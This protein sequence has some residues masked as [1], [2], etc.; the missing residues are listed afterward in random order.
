MQT[1]TYKLNV[2][3]GGIPLTI[4]ISQY[5]VGLRQYTFEPYTTVGSFSYVAGATVTLEATKPDGYAVIHDCDYNQDGSITYTVQEQLA[6]K[7]GRVW[8]KIVIRDG[9]DVLGTGA[10]VWVVD[11]AGMKDGTIVSTSDI[12]GIRGMIDTAV[13]EAL[14]DVD[15]MRGAIVQRANVVEVDSLTSLTL[16][17]NTNYF[18]APGEYTV[19]STITGTADNVAIFGNGAVI[20]NPNNT[21]VFSITGDNVEI[22]G[23][24]I[25][26]TS[27]TYDVSTSIPIYG[28][29]QVEGNDAKIHDNTIKKVTKSGVY[30]DGNGEIYGNTIDGML[31]TGVYDSVS[32]NNQQYGVCVTSD[33]LTGNTSIHDNTI[34]N[35][36]EGAYYGDNNFVADSTKEVSCTD[37]VFVDCLDHSIYVNGGFIDRANSN[38][39]T[40]CG[41]I[42][43]YAYSYAEA[44]MNYCVD[45]FND[46][47]MSAVTTYNG[48]NIR[49][50]VNCFVAYNT[51]LGTQGG[52]QNRGA[53]YIERNDTTAA[54]NDV[55]IIG[56]YVDISGNGLIYCGAADGTTENISI[57]NNMLKTADSASAEPITLMDT[58]N[59]A[60]I[61]NNEVTFS[62][63]R[64]IGFSFSTLKNFVIGNNL[65]ND[66]YG[67]SSKGI[68]NHTVKMESGKIV[69]NICSGTFA[70]ISADNDL[71]IDGNTMYWVNT[72]NVDGTQ[73]INIRNN[74][75]TITNVSTHGKVTTN[76]SGVASITNLSFTKYTVLIVRPTTAHSTGFVYNVSIANNGAATIT[77]NLNSTELEWFAM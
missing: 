39:C 70:I 72:N 21:P 35:I 65:I 23:F 52:T 63:S 47:T 3:P 76:S 54:F 2:T 55:S 69:N 19:S 50:P 40:R 6:A 7:A 59:K 49:K 25:N 8:S 10:I 38:E 9:A 53:I 24:V 44:K 62:T 42:S 66:T 73:T 67:T 57:M 31:T 64:G 16:E 11:C 51:I 28:T 41:Q 74:R 33:A 71:L 14:G 26:N 22:C 30:V 18:I 12:S 45:S 61:A 77:T 37:N 17:D 29:I 32:A 68:F 43:L 15:D 58:I 46:S 20:T 13:A 27:N 36:I 5:D 1:T 60:V 75:T 48:I 4:H 56:N 34:K